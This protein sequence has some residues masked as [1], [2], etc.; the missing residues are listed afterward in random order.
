MAMKPDVRYIRLYTDGSAARKIQP[1]SLKNTIRL[2]K[3]NRKKR[4]VLK[5]DPVAALG[6]AVAA[7]MMV[8]MLIGVAQLNAT[9]QQEAVMAEYVETLKTENEFLQNT[10][11]TGYDLEEVEQQ[12]LALGMVP[13]EQVQKVSVSIPQDVEQVP[14][15]NAWERFCI[16]LTDLFA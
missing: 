7:V 16:F 9:Q 6:M 1:V 8:L 2:P 12:A 13:K 5:I 15:P 11:S 10:Y 14:A 3:V 4:L